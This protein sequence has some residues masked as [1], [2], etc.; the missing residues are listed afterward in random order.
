MQSQACLTWFRR[1]MWL[2]IVANIVVAVISI[3]A[4]ATVLLTGTNALT[5]VGTGTLTLST[6][7]GTVGTPAV[8]GSVKPAG[9]YSAVLLFLARL[10]D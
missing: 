6:L 1:I 8:K 9:A 5:K 3:A 2:G 4:T 10:L 7:G